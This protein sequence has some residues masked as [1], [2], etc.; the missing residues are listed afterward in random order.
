MNDYS[1]GIDKKDLC[2][3]INSEN[4]VLPHVFSSILCSWCSW[5]Y[6]YGNYRIHD[7]VCSIL[8]NDAPIKIKWQKETAFQLLSVIFCRYGTSNSSWLSQY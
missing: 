1:D 4:S 6:I 2:T 8:S 3:A 7:D 5:L